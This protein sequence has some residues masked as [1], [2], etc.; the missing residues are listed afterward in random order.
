MLQT[1]GQNMTEL[2]SRRLGTLTSQPKHKVFCMTGAFY[3]DPHK[4]IRR[5]AQDGAPSCA[6]DLEDRGGCI[7]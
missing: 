4:T 5:D 1:S 3:V 6:Y 2:L 7:S